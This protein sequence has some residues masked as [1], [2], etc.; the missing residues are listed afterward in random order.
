MEAFAAR[1]SV[2]KIVAWQ[3]CSIGDKS[4]C[5]DEPGSLWQGRKCGH[6]EGMT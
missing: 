3:Q 1:A 4:I 6:K 2:V 5:V